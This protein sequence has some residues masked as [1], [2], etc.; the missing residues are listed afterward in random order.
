M[1]EWIEQHKDKIEVFYFPPYAPEYNPDELANSNLKRSICQK[2]SLLNVDEL[3]HNIRSHLKTLQLNLQ[4]NASFLLLL[5]F[6]M[7]KKFNS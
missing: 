3:E 4:K 6:T 1:S 5:F 2:P 7:L